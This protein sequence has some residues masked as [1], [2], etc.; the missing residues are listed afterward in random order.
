VLIFFSQGGQQSTD[1]QRRTDIEIWFIKVPKELKR[2]PSGPFFDIQIFCHGR[3]VL[4]PPR[5]EN[6]EAGKLTEDGQL[7]G[8]YYLNG[9]GGYF[10]AISGR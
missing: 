2:L 8:F 9:L 3:I 4:I 1:I 5:S 6:K 7:A 10:L